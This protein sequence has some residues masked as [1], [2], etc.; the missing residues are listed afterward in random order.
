MKKYIIILFAALLFANCS[1]KVTAPAIEKAKEEVT[2]VVTEPFRSSAPAPGPA[3]DI[4]IGEAETFELD[5]GLTVIVVENHK[6]PRVSYQL[7]LKNEPIVEGDQKGFVSFA[8]QLM[9]QGTTTKSKAEIDEAIDFIGARF[10]TFD[11]GFFGSALTKHSDK[12]LEVATDVLFNANFPKEEFEKLKTQTL[13]GLAAAK[14][15]PNSMSSNVSSALLYGSDHPYGE[16]ETEETVNNIKLERCKEYYKNYFVPNNAYLTI[17]GDINKMEAQKM[18][19]QYFGKWQKK[20]LK[21]VVNKTVK[22]P[23]E[24]KV[25]FV[26][27]DGAVQSV[28]NVTY[29]V[30]LKPGSEDVIKASVMNTIL[31]GGFSGRLNQNLREDKAYTYGAR[32]SLSTDRIV[33]DFAAGA[34]VRNEVTDSSI[35]QIMHELNL[36]T[37]EPVEQKDLTDVIN[38]MA[39]GFAR[40]LESPQTI[41]RFALNT[42]RYNLPKDYYQTYLKKLAAVSIEDVSAMAKKYVTPENAYVVVVG[43][44]DDV[45]DKLIQFDKSEEI[46]YYDAFGKKIK[47]DQTAISDDITGASVV[48][49]YLEA[50]GGK[51]KLMAVTAMKSEMETNLMGQDAVIRIIQKMGKMTMDVNMG[52]MAMMSQ[53]FDGTKGKVSQM[54]QDQMIEPGTDMANDMKSQAVIFA[55]LDYDKDGYM[56]DL[57]G[58]E[59]VGDIKAYKIAVTDPDGKKS[60]EFYGVES[61]LLIKSVGMQQGASVTNEMKDYKEVDGIMLPHTIISSG[62]MPTPM[63]LKAKMYEI[64]PTLEDSVFSV[65]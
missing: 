53:V 47:I 63:T 16:I 23:E 50:I 39:G 29:P 5:N 13:S 58:I 37:K 33:G 30:N 4:Q 45:A 9:K 62:A 12:L 35:V 48:S 32:S 64:N 52:G 27:K 51:D 31:G 2:K 56:L 6:L 24:T 25:A 26:N 21:L 57:K 19:E 34:S 3:R 61:G 36:I 15:D 10:N 49:D 59:S 8:G 40:S 7:S 14:T 18:A 42:I 54:G 11:T 17:V 1:K 46:D 20:P 44:K 28:I 43:S 55:Q 65:E 60:T 38:Y 41:A 22:A